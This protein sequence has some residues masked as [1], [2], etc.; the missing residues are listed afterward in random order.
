MFTHPAV[1]KLAS[2]LDLRECKQCFSRQLSSFAQVLKVFAQLSRELARLLRYSK[3]RIEESS[4]V[5]LR[6]NHPDD[7]IES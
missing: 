2:S 5:N 6:R 4:S 3:P 7:G 1:F